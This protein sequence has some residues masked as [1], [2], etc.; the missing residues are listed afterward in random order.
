MHDDIYILPGMYV[1]D[2]HTIRDSVAKTG[3][4][5]VTHEAPLTAGFGAEIAAGIQVLL[6]LCCCCCAAAV[7]VRGSALPRVTG[8]VLRL[9]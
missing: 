2:M 1:Q 9:T 3:R 5:V 8:G 4:I 7:V 6:L